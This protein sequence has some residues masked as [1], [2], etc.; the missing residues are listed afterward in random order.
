MKKLRIESVNT[1]DEG[2]VEVVQIATLSY[3]TVM[4]QKIGLQKY[5]QFCLDVRTL[6][7]L[8]MVETVLV[9]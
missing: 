3:F 5:F 6:S 9:S 4:L 2:F 8:S 1:Q 7:L